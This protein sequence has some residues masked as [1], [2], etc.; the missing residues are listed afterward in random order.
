MSKYRLEE[1]ARLLLFPP[2]FLFT[3]LKIVNR[4]F[5]QLIG[6]QPRDN[7]MLDIKYLCQKHSV[8]PRGVIHIG[9]HEGREI[10]LYQEM[11][12]KNI[13]FVE[14]N[15][16]VFERLK[17]NIIDETNIKAVNCAINNLDGETTLYV[18]S[19]DLSSS[20]LRLKYHQEI[21]PSIIESHQVRV[22]SKR[23]DS[24]LQEEQLEPSDFNIINIDIQGAE[25]MAFEGAI[26]TLKYI[27]AINT[28]VNYRE[29]YEGCARINQIDE[30]LE[31]HGFKRVATTTPFH[32]S[33][34]DA[35]YV[36]KKVL[37]N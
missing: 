6:Q 29:L 12:V 25:L 2:V 15:P 34:G 1:I 37:S 14:A 7:L 36:K 24:L 30:F 28:E 17:K 11:G 18:T 13:V 22:Q 21:Y 19:N 26:T 33:W 20:I 31:T 35:F 16:V 32:P 27:E 8:M 3:L 9:A 10:N 5:C 23:L 4:Q